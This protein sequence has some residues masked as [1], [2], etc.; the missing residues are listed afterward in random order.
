MSTAYLL[1]QTL[2]SPA[3]GLASAVARRSIV[4]PLL[5]ATMVSLGFAAV[6]VPRADFDSAAVEALDR[7]PDS[8]QL[9]PHD[10]EQAV[11]QARKVRV[12]G[13]YAAALLEPALRALVAAFFVWAA[14]R[15]A[16]SRPPFAA[17]LA[18]MSWATL[19][20]ALQL[21]LSF[22]ALLR[23]ASVPPERVPL[24]LP[25]SLAAI[26]PDT[27]PVQLRGL[28][29]ALDLFSLWAL[30]LATIGL[31]HVAQ[32]SRRRAAT[33][34]GLVWLAFVLVVDVALPG[35]RRPA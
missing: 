27:A 31:A 1:A 10:R 9:S 34:V 33:I 23:S 21:L 19:P 3:S 20:L 28:A 29:G 5:L 8:E 15:L 17:T 11:E 2:A 24:L 13:T 16:L 35:F 14:F 30:A 6:F 12:V 7:K 22:P 4:A 26:L 25:S 18:V 32:V